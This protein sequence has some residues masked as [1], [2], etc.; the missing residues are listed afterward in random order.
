MRIPY[1]AAAFVTRRSVLAKRPQ[2]IGQFMRA[3]A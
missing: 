1:A 2:V 3:M